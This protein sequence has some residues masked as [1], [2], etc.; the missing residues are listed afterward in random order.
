MLTRTIRGGLAA[1]LL[2]TVASVA[3]ADH[4]PVRQAAEDYR[5]CVK[6]FERLVYKSD[7]MNRDQRKIADALEDQTSDVLSRAKRLRDFRRLEYEVQ[8]ASFIQSQVEQIVFGNPY[9]PA[10]PILYPYW[11]K[12]LLAQNNLLLQMQRYQAGVGG[13]DPVLSQRPDF[14]RG[15]PGYSSPPTSLFDRVPL[16]GYG[17]VYG[18]PGGGLSGSV[19]N[20]RGGFGVGSLGVP[21]SG[22]FLG[23]PVYSV[24]RYR[25]Y[26]SVPL[27]IGSG[28]IGRD[29]CDNGSVYHRR[30]VGGVS[31]GAFLSR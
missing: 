28:S 1:I 20:H 23:Q 11:E 5:E 10:R 9:C 13:F 26:R 17:P 14:G 4:C 29:R 22:A 8:K 31:I 21:G 7:H 2:M 27:G 19:S 16:G 24:D 18:V 15:I 6:D 25:S 12:V 30:N 3:R